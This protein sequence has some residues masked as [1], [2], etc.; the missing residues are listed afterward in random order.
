ME[1]MMLSGLNTDTFGTKHILVLCICVVL[2]VL[3]LFLLKKKKVSMIT[4]E[5]II[6]V[7]GFISES[8]KVFYYIVANEEELGGYLPKT[9]LPFHLC[10]IQILFFL[11]L[12]LTKNKTLKQ[13]LYSFMLPTCLAG[14]IFALL[15]PTSSARTANIVTVQYFMYHTAIVVF[16]IYLY[17]TDEVEFKFKDYVVSFVLLVVTLFVAIYLNSWIYDRE[18]NIN[19]MYVVNPPMD[20]LPYLN[21]DHG[22]L[23]Y[24]FHYI[25]LGLALLTICYIKP[26]IKAIK[27]KVSEKKRKAIK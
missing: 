23:V 22:W 27:F 4:L 16:A 26:I 10:S 11:I 7:I 25:F 14:G 15:L 17:L 8:L 24:I 18:S 12:N 5:R 20:G 6:L 2:A 13:T 19:F 21:K 9:D 1:G 3:S